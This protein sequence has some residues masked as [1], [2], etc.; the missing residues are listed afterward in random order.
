MEKLKVKPEGRE[1]IYIATADNLKKW[2]MSKKFK[3][4]HN[5]IP[6]SSMMI[7]AD[8]EVTE[9]LRD[10]DRADRIGILIESAARNNM[11]HSLV[12]VTNNKLEM[13]D[14]GE[15]TEEDLIITTPNHHSA[16]E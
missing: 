9:V 7:G 14:I 12:L 11:N 16:R 15:I 13:Y 1:N 10:I 4:I 6:S 8:H 2:I 5:I 3:A